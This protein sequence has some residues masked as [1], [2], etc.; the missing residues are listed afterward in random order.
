MKKLLIALVLCIAMV[1]VIAGP[2]MA[3]DNQ[4]KGSV[5]LDLRD[6][7]GTENVVGSVIL[8]TTAS[9]KLNVL[10]NLDDPAYTDNW[11]VKVFAILPI[12]GE[13]NVLNTNIQGQGN[14]KL[15]IDMPNLLIALGNLLGGFI[16]TVKV[17]G[18]TN[19]VEAQ[20]GP[21]WVPFK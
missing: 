2:A 11:D 7:R 1:G 12:G 5:K 21:V 18:N 13:A 14:A 10:V 20:A 15:S 4:G 3:A 16:F 6:V 17:Y 19:K 8:N 9:G